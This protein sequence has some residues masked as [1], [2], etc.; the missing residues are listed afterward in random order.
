MKK[1]LLLIFALLVCIS[2]LFAEETFGLLIAAPPIVLSTQQIVFIRSLKE[3]YEKIDTWLNEAQDL[4]SFVIDGQTLRF[5]EAGEDPAVY[6]NRTTDIDS[7]EPTETTYD[8]SLDYYDSQNYKLRN[9]NMHALPFDKMAHYTKKS[10]K[11]IRKKE[12]ADAAYNIAPSADGNKTVVIGTT[13]PARNGLKMARLED[14][15]S[16]ARACDRS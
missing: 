9:I 12:I 10:A 15:V 13:G 2:A 16:L 7:V 1:V 6:K 3:E 4:G 14:I 8:V 11:A 5:P